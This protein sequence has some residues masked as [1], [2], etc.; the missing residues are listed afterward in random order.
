MAY[1]DPRLTSNTNYFIYD[2]EPKTIYAEDWNGNSYGG[3]RIERECATAEEAAALL[4]ELQA[5]ARQEAEEWA[6]AWETYRQSD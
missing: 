1:V 6:K 4:H 2:R 5:P 3:K